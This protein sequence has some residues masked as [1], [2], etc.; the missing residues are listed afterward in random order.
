MKRMAMGQ[1]VPSEESRLPEFRSTSPQTSNFI[2]NRR[3][4]RGNPEIL[5][6]GFLIEKK[7]GIR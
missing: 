1:R 3:M 6:K 7:L 5:I 4:I 2:S